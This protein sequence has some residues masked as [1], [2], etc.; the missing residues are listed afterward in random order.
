MTKDRGQHAR[1][2][3]AAATGAVIDVRGSQLRVRR[4]R[5]ARKAVRGGHAERHREP[6]HPANEESPHRRPR[7]KENAFTNQ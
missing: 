2:R 5:A 7:G 6:H 1:R 4:D 3:Q